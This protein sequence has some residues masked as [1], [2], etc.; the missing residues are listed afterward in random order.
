MS[1]NIEK[2]LDLKNFSLKKTEK[3]LINSFRNELF[4]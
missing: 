2:L 1:E 4:S 3:I